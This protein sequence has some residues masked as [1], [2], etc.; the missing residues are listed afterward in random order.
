MDIAYKEEKEKYI[1]EI[2]DK[3]KHIISTILYDILYSY[4]VEITD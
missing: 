3:Y 1:K 2:A 4:T